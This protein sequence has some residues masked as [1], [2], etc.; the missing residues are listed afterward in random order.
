MEMNRKI[1]AAIFTSLLILYFPSGFSTLAVLSVAPSTVTASIGDTFSVNITV[2]NV[3]DLGGWEFKLYYL[4]STLNG[5]NLTEGPFLKQGGST[6]FNV[7]N[8]T[9]NY[10][11]THGIAWVAC[12]LLGAGP[13]VYGSGTLAVITFR[14]KQLGT[15]GLT[16]TDTYLS[17]SEPIAHSTSNGIV[18]VLPH[19]IALTNL[20]LCKTV[21]GQGLTVKVNVSILN[22][23]NFTETFNVTVYAN[24]DS[25]GMETIT[26]AS[27]RSK[28][29]TFIWNTAGFAKSVYTI[30]GVGD[31]LAKETDTEDNEIINGTVTVSIP[32]DVDGNHEVD[33]F[34]VTAI[35]ICYDSKLGYTD[36]RSNCDTDDSGVIDIFDVTTA[37]ITYGQKYP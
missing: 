14:A 26:L 23:G 2:S 32:G 7:V 21:V 20:I 11:S 25:V 16:L 31:I 30:H 37:C 15:S 36:Y 3:E 12:A 10:N 29:V 28:T 22:Q 1:G 19:D 27:G 18:H 13:G 9:D 24:T 17:D 6:Y 8:F 4:S 34:D 35:C 5:T 33:I